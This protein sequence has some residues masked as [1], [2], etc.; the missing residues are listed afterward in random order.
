MGFLKDIFGGQEGTPGQV[1]DATPP[2]FTALRGPLADAL[3]GAFTGSQALPTSGIPTQTGPN[4]A[5]LGQA[6]GD[7]LNRIVQQTL[8]QNPLAQGSQNVLQQTL[9]GKFLDPSSNPS[10]AANITAAQRPVIE[11]FNESIIPQL[12]SAFT[13]AGQ[14]IQG[15]GSS[16]FGKALVQSSR[17]FQRN[18]GDISTRL[19]SD[20]F[21]RERQIQAGAPAQATAFSQGELQQL[22]TGLQASAL[23]R[24]IEQS[25]IEAGTQEFNKQ[26]NLLLQVLSLASGVSGPNTAVIP[27]TGGSGGQDIGK[28]LTGAADLAPFAISLLCWVAREVYGPDNPKW[29]LFRE[30]M[31]T[32]APRWLLKAY[33][34]YG[35]RI[36]RW[37]KGKDHLKTIIRGWM[38][39]RIRGMA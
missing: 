16:P 27:P 4:V 30:W 7:I 20:N 9:S 6:E 33:L 24:F 29:L 13:Q 32:R 35:E 1:V 25:G 11:Q 28:L 18:L 39:T 15:D 17:D 31:L 14:T 3:R 21:A 38:D 36:A 5:P 2:E 26:M 23:P 37:L 19:V 10:L 34:T 22:V 8:G 12:R